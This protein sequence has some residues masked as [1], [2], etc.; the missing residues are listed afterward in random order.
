MK[1]T[2]LASLRRG[3][4]VAASLLLLAFV[5]ACGSSTPTGA[6][7]EANDAVQVTIC[8]STAAS[9]DET[10]AAAACNEAILPF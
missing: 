4:T 5:A 7:P 8:F 3:W 9:E 2:M 10:E 1:A 6:G